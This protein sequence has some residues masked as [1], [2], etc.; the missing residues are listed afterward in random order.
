MGEKGFGVFKNVSGTVVTAGYPAVLDTT[1]TLI[2][3]NRVTKPS[4]AALSLVIGILSSPAALA[5][6]D[7]GKFQTYGY[8]QSAFV[9]NNTS[10]AVAA[11]DILVTVDAQWY[12]ARSA[13]GTGTSGLIM[14][15]EAFA[16]GTT[17][18]A[19]NKKVFIRAL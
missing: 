11:G 4:T 7:Y 15:A 5:V 8:N 16:T 10:V 6:D 19:A 12:M 13:A 1:A 2:D 3:G 14:A 9:T 18:A 17:P